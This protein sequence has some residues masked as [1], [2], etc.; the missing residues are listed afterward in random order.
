MAGTNEITA[1]YQGIKNG[2]YTVGKYIRLVYEYIVHGL[3]TKAFFFDQ[4]KA[5]DAIE[6]IE[7]HCF[8]T[9][10]PLAP[11]QISLEPWQKA[12]IASVFGLVDEK[13]RRQFR[14]ILRCLIWSMA[15]ETS[16]LD[17]MTRSQ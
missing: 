11:G 13:G 6:W 3:E 1:Y 17:T 15:Q 7:K 16:S 10:G 8:H 4:K 12:F 5:N 9:E 2:T 14:E